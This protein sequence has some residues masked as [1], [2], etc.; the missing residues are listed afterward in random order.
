M[1]LYQKEGACVDENINACI[2]VFVAVV[3]AI[4]LACQCVKH[5][6][7]CTAVFLVELQ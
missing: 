4:H 7:A 5:I 3:Y 2:S 1:L 6:H